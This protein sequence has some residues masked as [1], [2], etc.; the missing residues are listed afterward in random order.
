MAKL[1]PPQIEGTIPAFYGNTITVP[2]LMNKTVSLNEIDGFKLQFK[3]TMTN[4]VLDV[5]GIEKNEGQINSIAFTIYQYVNDENKK[6]ENRPEWLKIGQS[7]KIQ[8]AYYKGNEIGYYS[9]VGIV[10]YTNAPEVSIENFETNGTNM[11][12]THEYI[13]VYKNSDANEKAYSYRFDVYNSKNELYETSGDLLHNHEAEDAGDKWISKKELV[14]G[15]TYFIQ[16]SVVTINKMVCKSAKYKLRAG[17]SIY[18]DFDIDIKAIVNEEDGYTE[19]QFAGSGIDKGKEEIVIGSFVITRASSLDNFT[20]WTEINRFALMSKKPSSYSFKDFTIQHGATYKYAI[21]QYN[22]ENSIFS[23]KKYSNEVKSAFE[24]AYI[25]DGERQLKIKFNPKVSSFKTNIQESKLDMLGGKYPFFFRNKNL[26]YKEFPISGLISYLSDENCFFLK[27]EELQ[28]IADNQ[29]TT[30]LEDYNISAERIFK[31]KVLD[32]LTDGK[33]KL[34]RSPAEGNYIVRLMNTSLTPNDTVGRMLHTFNSTAYQISDYNSQKLNEYGFIQISEPETTQMRFKTILAKDLG[35]TGM[36]SIGS[37]N[38]IYSIKC[39][40]FLPGGKIQ[41]TYNDGKTSEIIISYTGYYEANFDS[42]LQKVA[43]SA[44]LLQGQITYSYKEDKL[45][46]F[47]L[48][49]GIKSADKPLVQF[50]GDT[51]GDIRFYSGYKVFDSNG[52]AIR[53]YNEQLPL[54]DI[55]HKIISYVSIS[56]IKREIIN[57]QK[58][59][60]SY[61]LNGNKIENFEPIYIYHYIEEEIIDNEKTKIDYYLDGNIGSDVIFEKCE[62]FVQIDDEKIDLENTYSFQFLNPEYAPYISGSLGTIIEVSVIRTEIIYGI[63]KN[64]SSKINYEEIYKQLFNNEEDNY[65]INK[66]HLLNEVLLVPYN[67]EGLNKKEYGFNNN[68]YQYELEGTTLKGMTKSKKDLGSE[69]NKTY[70]L[71][72]VDQENKINNLFSLTNYQKLFDSDWNYIENAFNNIDSIPTKIIKTIL[73]NQKVIH[74][75]GNVKFTIKNNENKYGSTKEDIENYFEIEKPFGDAVTIGVYFDKDDQFYKKEPIG[76]KDYASIEKNQGIN[77]TIELDE[78]N[79]EN[80]NASYSFD[81]EFVLTDKQKN[82][83]IRNFFVRPYRKWSVHKFDTEEVKDIQIE[84]QLYI[85]GK[86]KI[87]LPNDDGDFSFEK[88]TKNEKIFQAEY[89]KN[90]NRFIVDLESEIKIK[91]PDMFNDGGVE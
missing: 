4:Q 40:D 51:Q 13:G 76:T 67:G 1:Y 35:E 79:I 25:S 86:Y 62:N 10:K 85:D 69:E 20:E 21:Q 56:A 37:E 19:L 28:L 63:E 33:P 59:D 41:I 71:Q 11:P 31:M 26:E 68:Y 70:L 89:Y 75:S 29:R 12:K 15:E 66:G 80:I 30:N 47:D 74:F 64:L 5:F 7:Y 60:G 24:H 88:S 16:Y 65:Q 34:F 3:S 27:N 77:Y 87:V 32:F 46:T 45:N 43:I 8:L 91:Y 14:N 48:Y 52:K 82:Y 44:G 23:T 54:E 39:E 2:Y 53:T 61:Y 50:I 22:I 83:K 9:T 57:I 78:N 72:Y 42:P 55:K 6:H 17:L 38:N 36:V 18:P 58:K 49:S 90:Y 84:Y 81:V 73:N